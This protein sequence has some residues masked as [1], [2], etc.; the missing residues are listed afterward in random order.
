MLQATT[1][2][3]KRYFIQSK[4]VLPQADDYSLAWNG[5]EKYSNLHIP[6]S[7]FRIFP[8]LGVFC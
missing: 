1:D 8:V 4:I 5:P 6:V 3:K 7:A 2:Q